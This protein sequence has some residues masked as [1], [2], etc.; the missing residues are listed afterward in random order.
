ML[1]G[2]Q[3]RTTHSGI[4]SLVSI[5]LLESSFAPNSAQSRS[6]FGVQLQNHRLLFAFYESS[7]RPFTGR[8]NV[9]RPLRQKGG[10]EW[11]RPP[12]TWPPF[13]MYLIHLLWMDENQKLHHLK[14]PWN[15]SIPEW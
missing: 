5:L 11:A 10:R 15:D 8:P 14:T 6:F 13:D 1:E 7:R 12:L 4:P 3:K 9:S 2:N